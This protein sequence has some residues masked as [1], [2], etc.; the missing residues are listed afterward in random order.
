M[1]VQV[2]ITKQL[3]LLFG[4][5]RVLRS[6]DLL[7]QG[8]DHS[9][10]EATSGVHIWQTSLFARG[11]SA[12]VGE[13][14]DQGCSCWPTACWQMCSSDSGQTAM[15]HNLKWHQNSNKYTINRCVWSVF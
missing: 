4:G 14:A 9:S 5:E 6:A 7:L 8:T 10:R 15:L 3:G 13:A 12:P 11:W 1:Y 2:L